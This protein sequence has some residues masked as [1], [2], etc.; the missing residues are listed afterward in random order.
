MQNDGFG[1]HEPEVFAFV[2][3]GVDGPF[4]MVDP[5]ET[6]EPRTAGT[7]NNVQLPV[8]LKADTNLMSSRQPYL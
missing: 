8:E 1:D 6:N 2:K 5:G 3:T 4:A 7:L